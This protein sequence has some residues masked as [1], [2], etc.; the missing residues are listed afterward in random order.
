MMRLKN[1]KNGGYSLIELIA[2]IAI[3]GV[4]VGAGF[5]GFGILNNAN[6]KETT[7]KIET[8]INKTK[9]SSMSRSSASMELY[10]K[11]SA[12]YVDL[13]YTGK[14]GEVKE[15]A[16]I[17]S[18]KVTITYKDSDGSTVTIGG[19]N[20]LAIRFNRDTGGFQPI[21]DDVYCKSITVTSGAR[22]KT[23]VCEKLT[24]KIRIQ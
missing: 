24:G 8:A 2:V 12:Y 22:T 9:T 18:S 14:S 21:Q 17:G 15:T 23:I 20:K 6:V 3:M 19:A 11:D 4:M 13:S 1:R 10:E 5:V 7:A 16:K